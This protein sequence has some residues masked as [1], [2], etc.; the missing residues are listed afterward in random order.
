MPAAA[1]RCSQ[2]VH[3]V[4]FLYDQRVPMRDGVTLSADVYLPRGNGPFPTILFRTPY[5]NGAERFIQWG[6]WWARRGYAAVAQD[7]RGKY[8]SEG[9]FYAYTHEAA[10][11][12]DTL[13]WLAAQPWCNGRIGTWGRSYGGLYQWLLAPL[14][15]PNLICMAPH[16]IMDDY[17]M[18]YH[19]VGGAFQLTLSLLAAIVFTTTFATAMSGSADLFNNRRFLRQLPLIDLDVH[20]IGKRIPFWRDWLT[21]S[22]YDDY[23]R[24]LSTLGQYPRI[25]VPIF[26]QCGWYDAYPSSTLR[27]WAAMTRAG[28]S[29]RARRHQKV[30]MGPWSHAAPEGSRMG[31]LDFG[32]AADV[33]VPEVELRW[34]DHWLKEIDTGF[35]A[36][37]PLQLFVMGENAWRGEHEWPLARTRFTPYYLHSGGRANSLFGDG[38]LTPDPPGTEPPDRYDYDPERPVPSLGGNNSTG[39]WTALA[40]EPIIPGPVDQRPIERRDDVLVYTSPPLER[41]LEVTGPVELVLYAASSARDTDFTAKLI[42]VFPNGYAM[43]VTE[44]IIRARYR[45]SLERPELLAPDEVQEYRLQLYATSNL[46]RRGH[47]LRVDISSSN[48][49]RFAR[50]LNTGEDVATGTRMQVARQT[51]LHSSRYPSHILLPVIPR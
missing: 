26:Q 16:V 2:P 9:V 45:H 35:M 33:R 18:D 36:E 20:A 1:L 3:E 49:P 14:G 47:R 8:E 17:F 13:D 40:E 19:Y 29:E 23:W 5:E 51:V 48:F 27:H 39:Q 50:N 21:H 30:L 6:L 41:D 44:G 10:D 37:P 15:H 46:F 38:T 42:D 22:T 31:E 12:Y 4:R 25:D 28:K 24:A 34:F 43:N 32:P 7:C 11:G